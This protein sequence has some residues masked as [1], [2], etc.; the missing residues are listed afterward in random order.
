MI[1]SSDND[2][3]SPPTFFPTEGARFDF[4]PPVVGS[5]WPGTVR[6]LRNVIERAVI[7]EDLNMITTSWLP[8]GLIKSEVKDPIVSGKDLSES[9][10]G[11]Q[12]VF[13]LPSGGV[14]LEQVEFLLVRQAMERAGGNQTR[15]SE[16]LGI[17][18]DQLRYRLKK[19]E[20]GQ[21]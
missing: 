13:N 10:E 4:C 20:E 14:N 12:P 3:E 19:M 17:S 9:L 7:L 6:E 21:E 5:R 11:S 18:R 1:S 15:A 8:R 2:A 16:L